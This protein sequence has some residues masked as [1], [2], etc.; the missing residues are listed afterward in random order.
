M[1]SL[2]AIIFDMDGTLADT[3]E[4]HRRAFNLAF[5]DFEFGWEWSPADYHDLLAISG[6]KERIRSYLETA[7]PVSARK[8]GDVWKLTDAVHRRKSE[9]YRELLAQAH[10]TLRPGVERLI[11]EARQEG[12]RLA[13][14]TSSSRRNLESLLG[15]TLGAN[16]NALF[17]AVVT[18]DVIEDKKP[19]PAAYHQALAQLA[20]APSMCIAVEDTRNGNLAAIAA[21]LRTVITTHR[22][23]VDNDFLGASLVID[24]LGEPGQPFTILAG[25]AFGAKYVNLELLR[26]LNAAHDRRGV[27]PARRD[28][29]ALAAE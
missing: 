4:I 16:A 26:R 12:I 22:Y 10:I 2:L 19:S 14:A 18:S 8:D 23:T 7:A 15:N 1:S 27:A 11:A 28:R 21:G 5:R 3:E 20:L 6:G 24:Q 29:D 25:E 9:I 17:E 13:I